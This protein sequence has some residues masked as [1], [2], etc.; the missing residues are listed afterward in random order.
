[1]DVSTVV[2]ADDFMISGGSIVS[3]TP[4]SETG[5]A[6]TQF[7]VTAT[8][9]FRYG[10]DS[11]QNLLD[12]VEAGIPVGE[13]NNLEKALSNPQIL[14]RDMVLSLDDGDGKSV[15]VAGNPVRMSR[16]AIA[17]HSYPPRLGGETAVF[18]VTATGDMPTYQWRKNGTN[19]T[20]GG[21]ISGT[22]SDQLTILDLLR[23]DSAAYSVEVTASAQP[24]ISS[25]IAAAAAIKALLNKW[26][27]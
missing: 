6:A 18:N 4:V 10:E 26:F 11:C 23:S 9:N 2:A 8:G 24:V 14:G 15:R 7:T 3:V 5:G 22:L 16:S 25:D 12:C 21:R 1:M 27:I 20:D 17:G 13:I 19:L